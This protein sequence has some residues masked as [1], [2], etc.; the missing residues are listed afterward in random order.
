M[1]IL[2]DFLGDYMT[3]IL[4]K[5]LYKKSYRGTIN[6]LKYIISAQRVIVAHNTSHLLVCSI[7]LVLLQI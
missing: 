7:N 6:E 2:L 5:W 3:L 1:T 4:K